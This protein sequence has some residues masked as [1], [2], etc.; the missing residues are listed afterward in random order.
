MKKN[1]L[2]AACAIV[3]NVN[4]ADQRMALIPEGDFRGVD[5]RPFDAPVWHLSAENG[6]KIAAALNQRSIDMVVDYEHGTLK[7]Q[8]SGQPAPA[9]G[10]LKSGGFEYVAGVGL[11]SNSWRWTA[12]ASAFIEAEEYR[13]LSPVFSYDTSGNVN[14]LLCVALTNTPNIDTLPE[15]LLAAA[16]Q[17]FFTST[18]ENPNVNPLL[19]L[20]IAKLGLGE[21]ATEDEVIVAANSY[22]AAL[23]STFGTTVAAN[24]QTLNQA[25]VH[26]STTRVAANSQA[27][28]DPSKFVPIAV[29]TELQSQIAAQTAIAQ[30]GEVDGLI[31]AACN[32]GR[33]RGDAIIGWAKELG[34]KDPVALKD[35]LGKVPVIPALGGRQTDN[36]AANNQQQH[37]QQPDA[38]AADID[39]QLGL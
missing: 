8:D 23:D 31:T 38:I 24:S 4:A 17:D 13:Y 20:L 12:N 39:A 26:I 1:L 14:G 9:A 10:W 18:Q 32:D 34:K 3:L 36:I 29:V 2:V 15:A 6:H 37:Q 22:F 7:S 27:V 11:C 19:K 25:L 16:A 35:Y 28:P 30:A 5:G 33:L 21:T